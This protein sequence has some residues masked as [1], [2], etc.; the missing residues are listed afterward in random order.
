VSGSIIAIALI[1]DH[2]IVRAG[3]RALI[4][5]QPDMRVVGEA[6]DRNTSLG[7]LASLRPDILVVDLQLRNECAAD[8]L[9]ELL[10][11]SGARAIVLTGSNEQSVIQRAI[12]AGATGLV[13]KDE[14]LEMLVRA[15]RAVHKGEAWLKRSMMTTTLSHLRETRHSK[16]R[17]NSEDAKIPTSAKRGIPN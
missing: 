1:E 8:F 11:L 12:L 13:F 7:L 9:E 5:S 6:T 3:L 16:L 10:S 4:E 17:P 14:D 15:I 2:S